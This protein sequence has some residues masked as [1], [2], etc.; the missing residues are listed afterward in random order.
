MGRRKVEIKRIEDKSSRQVTFSKRR[1][2]LIKK[3]RDLSVLCDVEVGLVLFSSGGK[4][5][6]FC[7]GNSLTMILQRYQNLSETEERVSTDSGEAEMFESRFGSF[8]TSSELLQIVERQHLEEPNSD[9]LS[10][11][12]LVQLEKQIE[13]AL[14]QLRSRKTQLMMQSIMALREKESELREEKK[15]LLEKIAK[16]ETD[17]T[18]T[19]KAVGLFTDLPNET[20]NRHSQGLICLL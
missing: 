19:N 9:Q 2:G 16:M 17:G 3:A 15:Q 10:V 18:N 7:S 6:E 8:Q 11:T 12:D 13:D 20:T 5:Y 1:G 4:L 14:I